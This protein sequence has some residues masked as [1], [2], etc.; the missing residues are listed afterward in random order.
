MLIA[1]YLFFMNVALPQIGAY[2]QALLEPIMV[3]VITLVGIVM[4]FGAVG[5]KI[6]NNLGSTIV[7]GIFK[8]IAYICQT[9]L[10]AIGWIIRNIF[11]I[12]PRVFYGSR[13][14]FNQ[15]CNNALVSNLLAI[16]VVIIV[17]VV[18]I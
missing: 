6:S 15:I 14:T 13:R 12:I 1:V 2:A 18:I 16:I 8:A 3:M 4:L 5:M 17:L 10:R 7:G 9:I 11:R